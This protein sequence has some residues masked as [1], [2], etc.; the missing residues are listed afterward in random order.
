MRT[1]TFWLRPA[2]ALRVVNRF[3]R[4]AGFD[5]SMALASSMLTAMIS[6]AILCGAVLAGIG[7]KDVAD[8]IIDRYGLTGAGADAVRQVFASTTDTSIG[9]LGAL[10][11]LISTLS[12][13]RAVQRLFEQTWQLKPLSV[14]NT[15]NDLKWAL[16]F[17]VYVPVSGW[18]F[19]ATG[20]GHLTPA[21]T[22]LEASLTG[23]FLVWGGW[24]LSAKRVAWRDL[25]PF[26]VIASVLTALYSVGADFYLPRLFNSYADRYGAVG[27]VFAML[28]AFF[29]IVLVVVGSAALGREVR[30]E[31]GR[32]RQGERPPDDEIR[33]EW[34][35]V[36][37]QMRERW[38]TT[39]GKISR[40][41]PD[42][43]AKRR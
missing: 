12:F 39:R 3:Q 34:D 22:L 16:V 19:A 40:F 43:K 6:L 25:L 26:G 41:R 33:R 21:A 37:D 4:I 13:A 15:V 10:F 18:L 9:V 36:V 23:L 27:V 31:L 38:H 32:I 17:L 42:R 35:N 14:R 20:G 28:S 8:R 7:D 29:G 2:F 30:D 24:I 5:R 11:L 1:L